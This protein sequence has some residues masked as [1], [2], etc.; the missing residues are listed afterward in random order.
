MRKAIWGLCCILAI[1]LASDSPGNAQ[2]LSIATS[3]WRPY[4]YLEDGKPAGFASEV[5]AKVLNK[6]G[7]EYR[8]E[9]M[10]WQRA[11]D[12]AKTGETDAV[13]SFSY[14]AQR[15]EFLLYPE[16][17]LHPSEYVLYI[18]KSDAGKLKFDTLDDLK[19]YKVGITRGYSYSDALLK[20]LADLENSEE[21]ENDEMNF[22]KLNAG[23]ID[24]FP[25]DLLSGLILLRKLSLRDKIAYLDK[26]VIIKDYFIAFSKRSPKIT[27]EF[28]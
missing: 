18:R 26:R 28:V 3:E 12:L 2:P 17:P 11:L 14:N 6:M 4:G 19:G 23:S 13:Y 27:H 10:P 8:I 24:F 21:A 1:L 15:A 5:L 25:E 22:E 20:K 9:F 7:V 16:T